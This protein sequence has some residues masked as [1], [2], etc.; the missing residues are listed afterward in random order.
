[1]NPSPRGPR[2][3]EPPDPDSRRPEGTPPPERP[4][5]IHAGSPQRFADSL[6]VRR[7][8]TGLS[9]NA[10]EG[11]DSTPRRDRPERLA[12]KGRNPGRLFP[13]LKVDDE[14]PGAGRC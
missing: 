1:M 5:R 8:S 12:L 11:I 10:P 2:Q 7:R 13:D 3:H 6:R 9:K 4:D 14:R